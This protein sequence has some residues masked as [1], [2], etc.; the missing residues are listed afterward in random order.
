MR[1]NSMLWRSTAFLCVLLSALAGGVPYVSAGPAGDP[2]GDDPAGLCL[3]GEELAELAA[4]EEMSGEL[5]QVASGSALALV[6]LAAVVY[7]IWYYMDR[8]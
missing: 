3:S 2:A 8:N 1:R 4:K 5:A 7:L 6:G